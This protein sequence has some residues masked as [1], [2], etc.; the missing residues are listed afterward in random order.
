MSLGA[1]RER[2]T[3]GMLAAAGVVL[4]G[5]VARALVAAG[6]S[7][8][9]TVAIYNGESRSITVRRVA[10]FNGNALSVLAREATITIPP[11]STARLTG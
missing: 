6:D 11:D 4:D 1:L 9:V 8:P 5:T 2:A 3:R 7:V 10:A